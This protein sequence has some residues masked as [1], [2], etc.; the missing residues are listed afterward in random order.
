M[1]LG[2]LKILQK[3]GRSFWPTNIYIR[4]HIY[5][6]LF[7]FSKPFIYTNSFTPHYKLMKWSQYSYPPFT[8][9]ET[10]AQKALETCPKPHNFKGAEPEVKP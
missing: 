10:E 1:R 6:V 5:H 7:Q 3:P 2:F 8:Y 4:T 9:E